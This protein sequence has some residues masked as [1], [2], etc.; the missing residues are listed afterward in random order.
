MTPRASA[1]ARALRIRYPLVSAAMGLIARP[2]LVAAVSEAGGLGLL[3]GSPVPVPV[4]ADWI[5]QVR[6]ATRRPFGVGL[7]V[8]TFTMGPASTAEH[9]DLLAS[10]H[11]PV[12]VFHW[13]HPPPDWIER[14]RA[15]GC[16]V[17]MSAATA[18]DA[19]DDAATGV[20]AVIAQGAEAGG[21]NR[22]E[23]PLSALLPATV[24]AVQPLPVLAAGGI[25]DARTAA[26]AFTRGASAVVVGTR[27]V[28]SR[29]AYAH[30]GYKA[31]VV[32]ARAGDVATTTIFGPE[33]PDQTMRVLRNR[34][35]REAEA[36][37]APPGDPI[38]RT[39]LFGQPVDLPPRSAL[40]PTPDTTGDLDQMCLA[41]GESA[42]L[43]DEVLPAAE[44]VRRIMGGG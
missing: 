18:Q 34:A 1:F 26:V 29:E 21:H 38:G 2:P 13:H 28:A 5:R 22:S 24:A 7:I 23:I 9:V 20:D 11:V 37:L 41:A 3:G 35:V 31:R 44:I 14:L 12:V 30:E 19:A 40:L 4:L 10:E 39:S 17:W 36:G 27:F 25:A 43:I 32:A 15:A 16:K 42:A 33:W 6:A 8:D